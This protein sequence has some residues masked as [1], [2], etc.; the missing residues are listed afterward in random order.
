MDSRAAL[1]QDVKVALEASLAAD[2]SLPR[3]VR[4]D[5]G[6]DR[7]SFGLVRPSH[8]RDMLATG[9][10][11]LEYQGIHFFLA[12]QSLTMGGEHLVLL[13]IGSN[14]D[15]RAPVLMLDKAFRIYCSDAEEANAVAASPREAFSEFLGRYGIPFAQGEGKSVLWLPVVIGPSANPTLSRE[16]LCEALGYTPPGPEKTYAYAIST[17]VIVRDG[18]LVF[19]WPYIFDSKAYV[20][21][22]AKHGAHVRSEIAA[23][24]LLDEPSD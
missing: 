9:V 19:A 13:V 5:Q 24:V 17:G 7:D 23:Q 20:A 1:I 10:Q 14:R 12:A 2:Q 22:A 18:H 11:V 16:E 15:P 21:D 8:G 4:I 3:T 6:F